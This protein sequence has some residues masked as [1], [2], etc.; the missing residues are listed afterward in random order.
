LI[1]KAD[2]KTANWRH[3]SYFEV[4]TLAL[5]QETMPDLATVS[6]IDFDQISVRPRTATKAPMV[7][8][9]DRF[10]TLLAIAIGLAASIG[11]WLFGLL[12]AGVSLPFG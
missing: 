6:V 2:F 4:A 11:L 9:K 5:P 3:S 10:H 8:D 7:P 1:L 12:I